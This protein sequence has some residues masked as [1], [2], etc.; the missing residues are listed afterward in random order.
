VVLGCSALKE[1]YRQIMREGLSQIDF[2]FLDA[3]LN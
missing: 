3:A 1:S 2:V